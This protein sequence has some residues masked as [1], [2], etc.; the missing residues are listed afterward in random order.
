ME[1]LYTLHQ[2]SKLKIVLTFRMGKL[3]VVLDIY[4]VMMLQLE[5]FLFSYST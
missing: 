5:P 4:T 1:L 3:P 2:E